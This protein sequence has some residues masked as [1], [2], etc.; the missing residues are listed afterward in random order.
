MNIDWGT[1]VITVERDTDPFFSALGGSKWQMDTDLFRLALKDE[2]DSEDGMAFLDTHRHNTEVTLAGV[3]FARTVEIINGYTITFTPDSTW[4][5]VLIGS[6]NN[7]ADVKNVNGVSLQVQNSA[8]LISAPVD[9]STVA[10]DFWAHTIEN[11]RPA[12]EMWR[13]MFSALVGI[14]DGANTGTMTFYDDTGTKV[15]IEVNVDAVGNRTS[16]ITKDGTP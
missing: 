3:T 4:T 10:A 8:G 16:F 11:G 2:E 15:R 14:V 12:D 7:I 13:L 5:A 6:N 9:T 1:K